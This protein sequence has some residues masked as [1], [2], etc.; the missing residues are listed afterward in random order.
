MVNEANIKVI[1]LMSLG[2]MSQEGE[3][4]KLIKK[5]KNKMKKR[6]K[7]HFLPFG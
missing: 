7:V 2:S 6:E 3:R 5:M 4:T 1:N